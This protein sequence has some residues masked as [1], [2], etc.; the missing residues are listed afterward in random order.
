MSD[1]ALNAL[2]VVLLALLP[3]DGSPM[4]VK[5]LAAAA[6]VAP[7]VVTNALFD[8]WFAG[9]INYD[10]RTDAYSAIKKGDQL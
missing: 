3:G 7:S 6:C 9:R 2:R 8:D 5:A 1:D 10:V 4:T